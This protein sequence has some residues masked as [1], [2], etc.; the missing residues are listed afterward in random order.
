MSNDKI[1]DV[2]KKVILGESFL[3]ETPDPIE[4][5]ET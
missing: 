5:E 1:E 2:I 3:A 4:E